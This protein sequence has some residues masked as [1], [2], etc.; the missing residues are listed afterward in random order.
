MNLFST[1][2]L[3]GMPCSLVLSAVILAMA[4]RNPR[5]SLQDY[6]RDIQAAAPPKTPAE[7]RASAYWAAVMVQ[8]MSQSRI[9]QSTILSKKDSRSVVLAGLRLSAA[10]HKCVYTVLKSQM[11]EIDWAPPQKVKQAKC[12]RPPSPAAMTISSPAAIVVGEW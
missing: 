4:L 3:Y 7:R 12:R 2:T 5:Y 1:I 8:A 6:P 9:S 11:H 10:L